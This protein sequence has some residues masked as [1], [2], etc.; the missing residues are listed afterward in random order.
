MVGAS[1]LSATE[2]SVGRNK[3]CQHS[4]PNIGLGVGGR[5][6]LASAYGGLTDAPLWRSSQPRT[7][8]RRHSA[9]P[10]AVAIKERS[11]VGG[12]YLP[13]LLAKPA[14]RSAGRSWCV[15]PDTSVEHPRRLLLNLLLPGAYL[16]WVDLVSLARCGTL[17]CSRGASKA[18]FAQRSNRPK[19]DHCSHGHGRGS[20]RLAARQHQ[21][22]NALVRA[23]VGSWLWVERARC[24]I[25][26]HTE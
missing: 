8:L 16:V 24:L 26:N 11:A 3:R 25:G 7:V 2:S 9:S 12:A 18:I 4:G 20:S 14:P 22:A 15:A 23:R 17:D 19:R 13:D 21:C 10:A 6:P 5:R 1:Y